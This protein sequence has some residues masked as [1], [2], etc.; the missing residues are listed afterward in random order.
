MPGATS[1]T[2]IRA[3]TLGSPSRREF[4]IMRTSPTGGGGSGEGGGGAE[5]ALRILTVGVVNLLFDEAQV[6]IHVVHRME[7]QEPAVALLPAEL[8]QRCR[9][10]T[11]T[12]SPGG[13]ASSI[14]T[15]VG[16]SAH[17]RQRVPPQKKRKGGP[18]RMPGKTETEGLGSAIET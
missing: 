14:T 9:T 17:Y 13:I 16:R 3:V 5:V 11:R 7:V 6:Q 2:M 12:K 10:R 15:C 4:Q 1:V 18:M 8:N